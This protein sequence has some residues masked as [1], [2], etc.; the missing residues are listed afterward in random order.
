MAI[1][2]A[3]SHVV[4]SYGKFGSLDNVDVIAKHAVCD[5]AVMLVYSRFGW[6]A[7]VTAHHSGYL[8]EGY[9]R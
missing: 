6:L 8:S 7:F 4:V 9:T 1:E 2:W 3:Q 5:Y